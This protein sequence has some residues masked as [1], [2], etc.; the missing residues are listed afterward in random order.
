VEVGEVVEDHREAEED[1]EGDPQVG[2]VDHPAEAVD[3]LQVVP[4]QDQGNLPHKRVE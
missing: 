1:S 3:H 4:V 2:Q